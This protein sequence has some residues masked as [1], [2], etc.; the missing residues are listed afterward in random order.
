MGFDH[1]IGLLSFIGAILFG[2]LYRNRSESISILFTM[3]FSPGYN[4]MG[5]LAWQHRGLYSGLIVLLLLIGT[6]AGYRWRNPSYTHAS[7]INGYRFGFDS[8]LGLQILEE[9]SAN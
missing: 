1:A 3:V 2:A 7:N 6:K 9:N 5:I 8:A 4:C